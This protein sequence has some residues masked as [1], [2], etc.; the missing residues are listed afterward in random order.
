MADKIPIAV[1]KL[2]IT[3]ELDLDALIPL[4]PEGAE[5]TAVEHRGQPVINVRV[6]RDWQVAINVA[7]TR[8]ETIDNV[9]RAAWI[10]ECEL[11]HDLLFDEIRDAYQAQMA[12]LLEWHWH[13][14]KEKID[15]KL[16]AAK[17]AREASDA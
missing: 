4:L 17:P 11:E 10:H 6:A 1:E 9:V 8:Q 2:Q 12:E 16:A 13:N 14:A 5:V 3:E 7:K 15:L